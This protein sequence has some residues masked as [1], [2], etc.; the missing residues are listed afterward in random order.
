M[1]NVT[2]A[3]FNDVDHAQPVVNRLQEAGFHPTLLDESRWQDRHFAEH[4]ASVKVQVDE[5]ES[6]AA[7]RQL[8]Q[9]DVSEHWLDQAVTCP[10][11]GSPEVDYPQVTRKFVLPALHSILYKL[12]V[13]EKEFYCQRCHHTWPTRAKLE[14][15]RDPLNWPVKNTPLR[16]NKDMTP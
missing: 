4:L 8:H 2:L 11:C 3:T 1:R 13:M 7:D 5:S 10:E 12:G 15:A 9:W 16:E 14:P 6:E